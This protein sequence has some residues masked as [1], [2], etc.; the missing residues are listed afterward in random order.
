MIDLHFTSVSDA[1][2]Q[3]VTLYIISKHLHVKIL[4]NLEKWQNQLYH[5]LINCTYKKLDTAMNYKQF[6][7]SLNR[8]IWDA[9]R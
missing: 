4:L 8:Y 7:G 5:C 1:Y 2:T 9:A 3:M 6:N